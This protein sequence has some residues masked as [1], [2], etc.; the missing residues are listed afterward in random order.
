MFK[1]FGDFNF[2]VINLSK[3]GTPEVFINQTGI[4]FSKRL[5][6]DMNY[7]AYIRPLI[8]FENKALAFQVCKQGDER[9]IKF[10]KPRTEQNS[11]VNLSLHALHRTARQLMKDVWKDNCRYRMEAIYFPDAKAMV[12]DLTSA[13]ELPAL[14]PHTR[15][16]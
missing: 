1:N 12:V 9:A 16:H 11:G 15:Q 10:S 7:P 5:V 2:E 3:Q 4:T 14:R 8:D 6:D 13:E